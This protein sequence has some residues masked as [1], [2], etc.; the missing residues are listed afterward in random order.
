MLFVAGFSIGFAAG[1]LVYCLVQFFSFPKMDID[2]LATIAE[3]KAR[4]AAISYR[5][6]VPEHD[7]H[8][9]NCGEELPPELVYC[10]R[11]CQIDHE[12]RQYAQ[13]R[14]GK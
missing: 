6:P 7:G 8:C 13:Q 4:E 12:K 9:L 5:K 3:E 1:M 14:N 2:D 11:D 10:D